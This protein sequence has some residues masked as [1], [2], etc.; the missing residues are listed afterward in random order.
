MGTFNEHDALF[1]SLTLDIE[2]KDPCLSPFSNLGGYPLWWNYWGGPYQSFS[3][4]RRLYKD[5]EYRNKEGK[6]HRTTGPAYISR[7]YETEIWYQNGE[8][9]RDG[10]PA[11]IQRNNMVWFKHGQLHRLDGPA[12]IDGAGPKQYWINGT[13]LP[14]KEYKKEIARMRRKGLIK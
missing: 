9:H 7:T 8:K 11:Y 14:P 4:T 1:E 10:G 12:V 2:Y 3:R 5:I 6:L 13:R